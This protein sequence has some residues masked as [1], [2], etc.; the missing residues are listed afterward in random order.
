MLVRVKP[1]LDLEGAYLDMSLDYVANGD[2]RYSYAT[3]DEVR[4]KL[5]RDMDSELGIVPK[6]RLPSR[7]FL[8]MV[9]DRIVGTSRLRLEL[10]ERFKVYGGHIGYD[11]RPSE[12]RLGH[13]KEILRQTLL[14]AEA[15][16]FSEVLITC[17]DD[18]PGS[19]KIIEA[20]GGR[21]I[22]RM[23]DPEEKVTIRRYSVV[24]AN[25]KE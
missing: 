10:N 18:N 12:R 24:L 9:G 1:S 5:R 23:F 3:L 21:L 25:P 19:F 20:N 6:D 15:H 7:S 2:S 14:E 16:G 11:V 13:G 4:A 17:D 22:D 8:F